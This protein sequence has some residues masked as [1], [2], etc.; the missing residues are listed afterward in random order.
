VSNREYI[1]DVG[2]WVREQ[3]I[4]LGLTRAAVA[5]G[6]GVSEV[7]VWNWE[8]GRCGVRGYSLHRLKRF[9]KRHA[10]QQATTREGTGG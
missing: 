5:K 7:S 8:T 2:E 4:A 10:T 9:Y 3:R 1:R 6:V